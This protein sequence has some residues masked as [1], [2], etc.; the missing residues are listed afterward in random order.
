MS[1]AV[2]GSRKGII[3]GVDHL[4][5]GLADKVDINLFNSLFEQGLTPIVTPIIFDRNG[6][7]LRANSDQLA[8]EI[9]V[10]LK[11]SAYIFNPFSGLVIN[12][13][14]IQNI[15]VEELKNDFRRSSLA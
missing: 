6:Q 15:P 4:N 7:S 10:Q 9:A 8:S 2:R 3:K 5:T 13:Q 14:G 12:E 11:A 1:N